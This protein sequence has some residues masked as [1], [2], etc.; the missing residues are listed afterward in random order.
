MTVTHASLRTTHFS[1][2]ITT[3]SR[4]PEQNGSS[5]HCSSLSLKK[6]SN[7]NNDRN[8][9]P[10]KIIKKGP[11]AQNGTGRSV[12]SALLSSSAKVFILIKNIS[13]G[14]NTSRIIGL[15]HPTNDSRFQLPFDSTVRLVPRY[16]AHL[17]WIAA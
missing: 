15:L 6:W 16:I 10:L 1:I 4:M 2:L 17:P 7:A 13:L 14:M 12:K 9:K 11:P 5:G 8:I 3:I